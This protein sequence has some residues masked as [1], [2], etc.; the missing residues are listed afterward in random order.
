MCV[1]CLIYASDFVFVQWF[2]LDVLTLFLLCLFIFV[3]LF[4]KNNQTYLS[5]FINIITFIIQ[6]LYA[7]EN[8]K[9]DQFLI[10]TLTQTFSFSSTINNYI[11]TLSIILH[12]IF[13]Y[14]VMLFLRRLLCLSCSSKSY[15][16]VRECRRSIM[17]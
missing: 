16:G 6:F 15:Q 11:F 17:F 1:F 7:A 12:H 2:S 4:S 5:L 14:H 9:Q 3:L 8:L 10:N 13:I